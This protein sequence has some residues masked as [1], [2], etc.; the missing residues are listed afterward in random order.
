MSWSW[1]WGS[2]SPSRS[3]SLKASCSFPVSSCNFFSLSMIS[4]RF[5]FFSSFS[6]CCFC[7]FSYSSQ[8][9]SH[10]VRQTAD[11]IIFLYLV[12]KN[13]TNSSDSGLQRLLNNQKGFDG[14][15]PVWSELG[16]KSIK[17]CFKCISAWFNPWFG[18]QWRQRLTFFFLSFTSSRFFFLLSSLL[19]T[20]VA[21]VRGYVL[22][23]GL[24]VHSMQRLNLI[25]YQA[26][27]SV[28]NHFY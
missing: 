25:N 28:S 22:T 15:T 8:Q 14:I 1:C 19:R 17:Q 2:K 10:T 12:E 11:T 26:C 20:D 24:M 7:S 18:K 5:R 16:N 6:C 23:C 3:T 4:A 9:T 21:M 27:Y 13:I